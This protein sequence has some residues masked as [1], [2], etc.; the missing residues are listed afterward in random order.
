M[1]SWIF[2]RCRDSVGVI[3]NPLRRVSAWV[4]LGA[5]LILVVGSWVLAGL[6]DTRL[7]VAVSLASGGALIGGILLALGLVTLIEVKSEE[8][9]RDK[10]GFSADERRRL[11]A[12]REDHLREIQRLASMR[13]RVDAAASCLT[14]GLLRIPFQFDDFKRET[15]GDPVEKGLLF[16]DRVTTE[17]IGV[18]RIAGRV[19]LGVDLA[20]VRLHRRANGE[21]LV[22]GIACTITSKLIDRREDLFCELLDSVASAGT[23]DSVARRQLQSESAALKHARAQQDDLERRL[24]AGIPFDSYR[25]L[26]VADTLR[27]LAGILA[28]LGLR[29]TRAES[30]PPSTALGFYDFIQ[31]ENA[32]LDLKIERSTDSL[33]RIEG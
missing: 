1:I 19:D 5:G 33:L 11:L 26:V 8:R 31:A 27:F 18:Q 29:L 2:R 25:D 24:D 3:L 23:P 16:K 20:Q 22:Y 30:P 17:Y 12:E 32:A 9:A 7:H 14:L 6:V 10:A 15:V 13:I 28:P 21:V 4:L